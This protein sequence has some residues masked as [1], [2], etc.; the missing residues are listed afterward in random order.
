[1]IIKEL[2]N[3]EHSDGNR[4]LV[5][6]NFAENRESCRDALKPSPGFPPESLVPSQDVQSKTI[7]PSREGP[8]PI[9]D[10]VLRADLR[11]NFLEAVSGRLSDCQQGIRSVR[12]T[13]RRYRGLIREES[14]DQRLPRSRLNT[15]TSRTGHPCNADAGRKAKK[16]ILAYTVLRRVAT[17]MAAQRRDVLVLGVTTVTFA[18]TLAVLFTLRPL[19]RP[20][21]KDRLAF[22]FGYYVRVCYQPLLSADEPLLGADIRRLSQLLNVGADPPAGNSCPDVKW[23]SAAQ[24]S[25]SS[26]LVGSLLMGYDA[27]DLELGRQLRD[28]VATSDIK[29]HLDEIASRLYP[30]A[31]DAV[32]PFREGHIN[33]TELHRRL[34]NP[35]E[36]LL[37]QVDSA[38]PRRLFALGY[39]LEACSAADVNALA[40]RI[41][42]L[43]DALRIPAELLPR[44]AE[45][46]RQVCLNPAPLGNYFGAWVSG[47]FLLGQMVAVHEGLRRDNEQLA[48]E[49]LSPQLI[50]MSGKL[51]PNMVQVSVA[52]FT[53]GRINVGELYGRLF[54]EEEALAAG[55]P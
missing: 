2:V 52:L 36:L 28:D 29:S 30:G 16:E 25:L 27:A 50:E 22:E 33:A 1:M 34:Y 26:Q 38:A 47:F 23:L 24:K 40:G 5:H 53:Q 11:S 43:A 18:I 12:S 31:Q 32:T 54:G 15:Q 13:L 17:T 39:Y 42:A 35:H 46:I 8:R 6:T 37:H 41:I 9:A 44:D 55:V 20:S 48:L 3:Q 45:R 4:R 21:Q 51:D 10:H 14:V 19:A 49:K 7:T